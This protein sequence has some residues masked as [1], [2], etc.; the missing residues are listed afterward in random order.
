MN[1]FNLSQQV[2]A[3]TNDDRIRL[4]HNVINCRRNLIDSDMLNKPQDTSGSF[5]KNTL[6]RSVLQPIQP[7]G[8]YIA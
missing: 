1:D 7:T 3:I 2:K 4:Y 8:V 6:R 5:L